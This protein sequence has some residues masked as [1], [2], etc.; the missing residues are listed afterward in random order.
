[1]MLYDGTNRV[2]II[3]E[4]NS[5]R[6]TLISSI[7]HEFAFNAVWSDGNQWELSAMG[8]NAEMLEDAELIEKKMT[9][10]EKIKVFDLEKT[11]SDSECKVPDFADLGLWI[12]NELCGRI[13]FSNITGKQNG[14]KIL[15][16]YMF[17][18][19]L[20]VVDCNAII[21][22][23]SEYINIMYEKMTKA[24]D[25]CQVKP[26]VVFA[27]TKADILSEEMKKNDFAEFYALFEKNCGKLVS[28]CL[29]NAV[30]YRKRAVSALNKSTSEIFGEDGK[31]LTE[32]NFQ[33]WETDSLLV[34]IVSL[35]IPL[36]RMKL[37]DIIDK[38]ND[39]IRRRRGVF[40]HESIR[41][42]IILRTARKHLCTTIKNMYP[43]DNAMKY[44]EKI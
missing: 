22:N 40:N 17:S 12:N 19:I 2:Y 20:V 16:Q 29:K 27:L 26:R 7:I 37:G 1:M 11:A 35:A 9:S 14:G 30:I 33:P 36:T 38:C 23:N 24:L 13:H 8:R 39:I 15:T 44:I 6:K 42:Q 32:P 3:G 34:D 31:M 25:I 28:H 18:V 21:N 4:K 10:L 5:G 43:L 41:S